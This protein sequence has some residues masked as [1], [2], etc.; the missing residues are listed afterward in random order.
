MADKKDFLDFAEYDYLPAEEVKEDDDDESVDDLV[1]NS[2][3]AQVDALVER[4][5]LTAEQ[6][7]AAE[8]AGKKRHGVLDKY[9]PS[10]G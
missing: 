9:K 6:V 10:E 1:A 2:T 8:S 3:A 4:G 5:D 7:Y